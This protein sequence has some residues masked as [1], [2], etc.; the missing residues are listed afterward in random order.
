MWTTVV[1]C[2]SVEYSD[3]RAAASN[4]INS[5]FW[6]QSLSTF[7]MN[8]PMCVYHQFSHSHV[9]LN[10]FVALSWT[11]IQFSFLLYSP[12]VQYKCFMPCYHVCVRLQVN[13]KFIHSYENLCDLQC[14]QPHALPS[15]FLVAPV[16]YLFLDIDK[17]TTLTSLPYLWWCF[18]PSV[19]R[20]INFH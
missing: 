6:S 15:A 5:T 20:Y 8:I 3:G 9:I 13:R 12:V 4:F 17:Q 18:Y 19:I 7:Y 14:D 1:L 10:N 2:T 11:E 16:S